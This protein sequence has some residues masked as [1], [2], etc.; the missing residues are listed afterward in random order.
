MREAVAI[1]DDLRA[2]E[3]RA[4]AGGETDDL[5]E[6]LN[7]KIAGFLAAGD[8]VEWIEAEYGTLVRL[9]LEGGDEVVALD[10]DPAIDLGWYGDFELRACA[11][12]GIW[13]YRKGRFGHIS[14][15]IVA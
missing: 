10:P 13:V 6:R 15:H 7:A 14:G 12:E 9:F 2:L 4:D 8:T 3:A 1:E 5:I 11:R